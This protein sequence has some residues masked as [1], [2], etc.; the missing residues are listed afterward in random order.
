MKLPFGSEGE[1]LSPK[2]KHQSPKI[3]EGEIGSSLEENVLGSHVRLYVKSVKTVTGVN[4]FE[5]RIPFSKPG[6]PPGRVE[7]EGKIAAG[8]YVAKAYTTEKE[9]TYEFVLSDEQQ[10]IIGWVTEIGPRL[11]LDVHVID[12][13]R[14]NFLHRVI[15]E[16][17]EKIKSFPPLVDN[18]GKILEGI[19]T[20]EQV[21]TFL[22][23]AVKLRLSRQNRAP[24]SHSLR[25]PFKKRN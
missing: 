10:R 11:G 9:V 8:T 13:G 3:L 22:S 24:H 1:V 18:S 5:R 16:E 12:V 19:L 17:F 15:Q 21:E 25:P 2:P 7:I 23:N 4:E 14:E 6:Q 20:K